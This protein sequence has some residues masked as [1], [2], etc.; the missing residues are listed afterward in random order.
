MDQGQRCQRHGAI[1]CVHCGRSAL[2]FWSYSDGPRWELAGLRET[3]RNARLPPKSCAYQ[4][5]HRLRDCFWTGLWHCINL[6]D[7][8]PTRTFS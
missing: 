5:H 3:L 7:R 2:H 6:D 8:F 4:K 1:P